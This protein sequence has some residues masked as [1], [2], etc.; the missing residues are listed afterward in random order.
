MSKKKNT[1]TRESITGEI[2]SLEG[3]ER[4][5]I[6]SFSSEEPYKR[7]YG[8]EI[9]DHSPNAIDLERLSEIGC[10]LFN[11][12]RDK[13]IAKIARVWTENNRGMAE[14]EFDAD[15]ESESIFQKVKGGSLKGVSVGYSVSAWES[16]DL[17]KKSADGRF[18]G[19]VEIAKRWCPYEIS[20]VSIPADPTV[21]V[22]RELEEKQEGQNKG[23]NTLSAEMYKKQL[24]I[25]NNILK[26]EKR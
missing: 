21:G 2:R 14:I 19:P 17:N 1:N 23:N 25:N 8:N 18:S 3:E 12:N 13:V 9:L 22:G 7:W 5:F 20:I 11:H 26:K 4:K 10:V 24:Q 15:T 16:V 6:L